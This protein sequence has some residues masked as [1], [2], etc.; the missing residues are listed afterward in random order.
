MSMIVFF[1]PS[2]PDELLL[3]RISR[4]H[5]LSG[6]NSEIDTYQDLFGTAPFPMAIIPKQL[7]ILASR[8]PGTK[9]DNFIELLKSNTSFPSYKPFVGVSSCA[10]NPLVQT[11]SVDVA[12][13]PR[14]EVSGNNRPQICPSCV[15]ADVVESGYS[16]WHR[17]HQMPGV[18]AC[19]QHGEVLLPS[20]PNCSHPFY[21]KLKLLPNPSEGC[22]CGWNPIM[23]S[24]SRMA[25]DMEHQ[26]AVFVNAVLQRDLPSVDYKILADCYR[27]QARI[28]GFYHGSLFG[29]AKLFDSIR[30]TYGDDLLSKIDK[31]YANGA[32][33]QW[34]RLSASRGQID[35]PLV[36]HLVICHHLFG[37]VDRFEKC[38][39]EESVLF[40]AKTAPTHNSVKKHSES[41]RKQCRDRIKILVAA[42]PG[43]DL[44]YLWDNAYQVTRWINEHDKAW[45][46]NILYNGAPDIETPQASIS[47]NDE[48]Y[49]QILSDGI[50]RLYKI[51]QKQKRVNISNMLALLPKRVIGDPKLRKV[52]YPELTRLLEANAESVWHFRLRRVIWAVS[53]ISRLNLPLNSSNKELFTSVPHGAWIAILSHFDCDLEQLIR[54]G[55]SNDDVLKASGVSRQWEGPP[56]F[57]KPMGGDAYMKRVRRGSQQEV[58]RTGYLEDPLV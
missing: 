44:E 3:S 54:S 34:I 18:T 16:Y 24:S 23:P 53:E 46:T 58:N 13:I 40:S 51:T 27:R 45:L 57:D 17:A 2:M 20:C 28:K 21:R 19:W 22:I 33:T 49:A 29:V 50:E 4:Y 47:F 55:V 6:N 31:A 43:A 25:S 10:K 41:K 32:S 42:K 35:M 52:V 36:R 11:V 56:G 15:R 8:L 48:F 14:R 26:Y 38:L 9:Q 12:R 1:P 7:E 39:L 30:A 37:S 5:L